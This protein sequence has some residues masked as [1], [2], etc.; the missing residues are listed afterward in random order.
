M[1]ELL[2]PYFWMETRTAAAAAAG[3]RT[4]A[5]AELDIRGAVAVGLVLM[6][7]VVLPTKVVEAARAALLPL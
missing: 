6:V 7:Q 2:H 3:V 4:V 5:R 1:E